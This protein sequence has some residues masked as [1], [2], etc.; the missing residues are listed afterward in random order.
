[1]LLIV[2]V[3]I[4]WNDC[5]SLRPYKIFKRCPENI[6]MKLVVALHIILMTTVSGFV[7]F[8]P[9]L[10]NLEIMIKTQKF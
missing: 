9:L 1:M 4:K 5:I 2:I 7:C 3:K 10:S 6:G 8:K